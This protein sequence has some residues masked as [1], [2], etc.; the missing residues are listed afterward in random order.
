V[1]R[2]LA[3]GPAACEQ[4]S[5]PHLDQGVGNRFS[6]SIEHLPLYAQRSTRR[7]WHGDGIAGKWKGESEERPDSL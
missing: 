5:V 7:R 2:T 1:K 6:V 4:L 3:V